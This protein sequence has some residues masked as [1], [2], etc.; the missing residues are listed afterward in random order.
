MIYTVSI[1]SQGQINIPIKIRRQLG[2]MKRSRANVRVEKNTIVIEPMKDLLDL[3]GSL[4]TTKKSLSN[5]EL[6]ELFAQEI[7]K[8]LIKN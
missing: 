3:K 2:L 6:H 4:K 7:I 5:D 8:D 1:T